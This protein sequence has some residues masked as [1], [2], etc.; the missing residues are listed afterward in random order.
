MTALFPMIENRRRYLQRYVGL[1]ESVGKM[2]AE[3]V[4]TVSY[5]ELLANPVRES[6]AS[7]DSQSFAHTCEKFECARWQV[8]TLQKLADFLGVEPAFDLREVKPSPRYTA[9]F[10]NPW[11]CCCAFMGKIEL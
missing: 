1:R 6:K 5:E 11:F 7:L 3:L 8:D 4:T 10:K 9:T 2:P